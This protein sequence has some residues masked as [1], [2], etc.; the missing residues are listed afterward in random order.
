MRIGKREFD[1][2]NHTYVMGILNV[3]PDSFS[4]GGKWDKLDKA[5]FRAEQMLEEGADLLDI[6]GESTRP[7]FVPVSAQE[8]A[9][10][11]L[12]VVEQIRS[13]FDPV[14]SVD[15]WKASV[16]EQA[17]RA[18]ADLINDIWGLRKGND[19]AAVIAREGMACCL[20]HNKETNVYGNLMADLC[21]ETLESVEMA[22]RAGISADRILV[23]PGIGFALDYPQNLEVMRHLKEF[24][25]IGYPVLLGCSRKSFIGRTLDL[26]VKERLPGTLVTT[27]LAVQ[28]GCAFVR[29]HD[30]KENVQAVRMAECLLDGRKGAGNAETAL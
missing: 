27:V 4:D 19:M 17:A 15:T 30:V 11:I 28:A 18:G 13:R 20:M 26:P 25:R 16:A 12:P 6:G 9:D 23:D 29:V 14:I 3:T 5:L 1:V 21:R 22:V 7:D 8:E 10:R 2:E 24:C